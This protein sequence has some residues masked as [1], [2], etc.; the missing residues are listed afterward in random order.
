MRVRPE[1]HIYRLS[2]GTTEV[3]VYPVLPGVPV[4]DE[5][6]NDRMRW[7]ESFSGTFIFSGQDYDFINSAGYNTRF[8]LYVDRLNADGTNTTNWRQFRF[9]HFEVEFDD[10]TKEAVIQPELIT[11]YA[12]IESNLDK[13]F[14]LLQLGPGDV[15]V[16][17][18][19]RPL[20]QF[21]IFSSNYLF[22]YQAGNFWETPVTSIAAD[23]QGINSLVEMGFAQ[24]SEQFLYIPETNPMVPN[25][26]GRYNFVSGSVSDYRR[27][28]GAYE[29]RVVSGQ[30]VLVDRND[31][32]RVVYSLPPGQANLVTPP[33]Y[34]AHNAIWQS[35]DDI[36]SKIRVFGFSS[37]SRVLT[38][39]DTYQGSATVELP[40]E[41]ETG[42]TGNTAWVNYF[43][44]FGY[45]YSVAGLANLLQQVVPF[46]GHS[47]TP[48][49]WGKIDDNSLGWPGDY[50]T[51]P[52]SANRLYPVGK[53][54]WLSCSYWLIINS[55]VNQIFEDAAKTITLKRSH[56]LSDALRVLCQAIDPAITHNADT[57]HSEFL[58]SPINPVTG[59][60]TR[61]ICITQKSNITSGEFE[62]PA[63]RALIKLN[64]IFQML[65]ASQRLVFW[66]DGSKRL[67]IEH[68]KYFLN[69]GSYTTPQISTDITVLKHF[70]NKEAIV[71]GQNKRKFSGNLK[72]KSILTKW[73]DNVSF[74]F[75]GYRIEDDVT[76]SRDEQT[77]IEDRIDLFTSDIDFMLANPDEINKDGFALLSCS[78]IIQGQQYQLDIQSITVN[79]NEVYALQNLYFSPF[80]FHE[81]FLLYGWLADQVS[82]NNKLVTPQTN[83]LVV[84]HEIDLPSFSDFD[85]DKLLRTDYGDGLIQEVRTEYYTGHREIK[86]TYEPT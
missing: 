17:A 51:K 7:E 42:G 67:R 55:T 26:A 28:D 70:R 10:D 78:E 31:S 43:G 81:K 22:N 33:F 3:Q 35:A 21:Y 54:E 86:L 4:F 52:L 64:N 66:I 49:E 25:V 82:V 72:Y 58:Y 75:E 85:K 34:T 80:Y 30:E 76:D 20:I 44:N 68:W 6:R 56:L 36:N 19:K 69:G 27:Q 8:T 14:D 61:Y 46:D 48:T 71:T 23:Q 45:R 47:V 37:W 57:L 15:S 60:A 24:T 84:L 41:D 53:A 1:D 77:P 73:M 16:S 59:D 50:F 11:S 29:L 38:D 74:A 9:I 62:K 63:T 2:D 12:A 65:W 39:L 5:K 79:S 32:D 83:A 40:D 18:Q 13:E